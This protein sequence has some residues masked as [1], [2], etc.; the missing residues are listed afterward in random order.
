MAMRIE[1][2]TVIGA[3]AVFGLAIAS[4]TVARAELETGRV[5]NAQGVCCTT[6]AQGQIADCLIPG[7][8]GSPG[9]P[10]QYSD[11]FPSNVVTMPPSTGLPFDPSHTDMGKCLLYPNTPGCRG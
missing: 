3:L 4:T 10:G 8:P 9:N 1:G 2:R 7:S 11:P 5:C 6:T